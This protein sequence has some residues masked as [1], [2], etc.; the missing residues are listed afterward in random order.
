MILTS[1]ESCSAEWSSRRTR[2]YVAVLGMQTPWSGEKPT[3][4]A[5]FKGVAD[6]TI[7]LVEVAFVDGSVGALHTGCPIKILKALLCGDAD[8]LAKVPNV[9]D[10]PGS[11][12]PSFHW[13]HV[14]AL[15]TLV[16]SFLLLLLRPRRKPGSTAS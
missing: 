9:A 5:D 3:Q 4:Q 12:T 7:L 15:V 8:A 16:L 6:R 10:I 14:T 2:L 13:A 1:N 11:V